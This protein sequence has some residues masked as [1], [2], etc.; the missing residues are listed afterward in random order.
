[1]AQGLWG[2]PRGLAVTIGERQREQYLDWD[3]VCR[4]C[5]HYGPLQGSYKAL[6]GIGWWDVDI[7][8]P[9]GSPGVVSSS[10]LRGTPSANG[11]SNLDLQPVDWQPTN[12]HANH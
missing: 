11:C 4:L 10:L 7:L 9:N 8:L 6:V 2:R 1:M 3:E 5:G 12:Q